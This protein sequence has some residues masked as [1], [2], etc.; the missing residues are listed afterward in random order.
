MEVKGKF[1]QAFVAVIL[2]VFVFFF[3]FRQEMTFSW[4][5]EELIVICVESY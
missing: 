2:K 3:N 4:G 1:L 5:I